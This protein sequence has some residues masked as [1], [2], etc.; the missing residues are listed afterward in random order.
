[1]KRLLTTS[2]AVAIGDSFVAF[3]NDGTD[4]YLF[5]IEQESTANIIDADDIHLIGQVSG[6]TNVANGDFVS[7]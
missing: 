4:G 5:M 7:F 6:C 1:M 2:T 3:M